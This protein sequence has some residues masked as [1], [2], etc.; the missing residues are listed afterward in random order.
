MLTDYAK[1]VDD[2]VSGGGKVLRL[3]EGGPMGL[4]DVIKKL[5]GG[6]ASTT[7][8]AVISRDSDGLPSLAALSSASDESAT[9]DTAGF[10]WDKNEN[11]FFEAITA[12]EGEGATMTSLTKTQ[13]C[14]RY[15]LRDH[16]HWQDVKQGVYARLTKKYGSLEEVMQRESN[17]RQSQAERHM[18]QNIARHAASGGFEPAFGITLEKWAAMNAALTQGVNFD[19]LL[20]GNGISRP[21][22]DRARAEWEARMAKDTTFAITTIYGQ[23]FQNASNG[24]YAA[25]VREA[26]AARS[27]NRDMQM[28]PP[29]SVDQYWEMLY[30]QAYAAKQGKDVAAAFAGMG[31]TV[32]DWVDL[33]TVM[34]YHIHRTWAHNIEQYQASMKRAE[35]A[36]KAK[37]PGVAADVDIQF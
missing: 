9:F 24:K 16:L 21:R 32:T 11:A 7:Q 20:K 6:S 22:W 28:P 1:F 23:A 36:I 13:T 26:N 8:S 19:D 31:L 2:F 27:A 14:Q 37:Y 30:E 4:F 25:H 3:P 33:G 5:I 10:D 15:G 34:G 12:I 35:A 29:T 17:F 18:Q